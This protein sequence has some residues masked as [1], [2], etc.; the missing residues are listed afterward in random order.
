MLSMNDIMPHDGAPRDSVRVNFAPEASALAVAAVSY[1]VSSSTRTLEANW[2][3]E[4]F[5]GLSANMDSALKNLDQLSVFVEYGK[6]L[7]TK[8]ADHHK[9]PAHAMELTDQDIEML[10]FSLFRF[11]NDG[12]VHAHQALDTGWVKPVGG[13]QAKQDT[14][15]EL[16]H[17]QQEAKKIFD[18][19][20]PLATEKKVMWMDWSSGSAARLGKVALA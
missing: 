19:L 3:T 14:H 7:A 15:E 1:Y 6:D 4:G 11:G 17:R 8:L 18:E 20:E 12:Y 16:A 9:N 5:H 10:G 2:D 13:E